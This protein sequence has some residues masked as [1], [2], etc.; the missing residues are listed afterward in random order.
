MFGA[1][2]E[3][4]VFGAEVLYRDDLQPKALWLSVIASA[5]GY[6]IFGAAEGFTP[7]FGVLHGHQFDHPIQLLHYALLGLVAGL[8]A[9]VYV[10]GFYATV[11]LTGACPAIAC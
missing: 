9:R 3:G 6:S 8:V 4:A 1:P 7:L 10:R 5:I 11:R 2:L